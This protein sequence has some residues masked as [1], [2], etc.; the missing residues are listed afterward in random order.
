M[1]V[2]RIADGVSDVLMSDAIWCKRS[3]TVPMGWTETSVATPGEFEDPFFRDDGWVWVQVSQESAVLGD[4]DTFLHLFAGIEGQDYLVDQI[5]NPA[6]QFTPADLW[7]TSNWD[8]QFALGKVCR[9]PWFDGA[10]L[11][12]ACQISHIDQK[13]GPGSSKWYLFRWERHLVPPTTECTSS[14]IALLAYVDDNKDTAV[15][16]TVA[17]NERFAQ[18]NCPVV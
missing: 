15:D 12:L 17:G 3:L 1:A 10:D 5:Q 7:P 14:N 6:N 11:Q 4:Q 9:I 13:P 16:F 18:R 2:F 8:E